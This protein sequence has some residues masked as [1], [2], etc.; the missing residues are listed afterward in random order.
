MGKV[1]LADRLGNVKRRH[2]GFSFLYLFL[3]P[4]YLLYRL[5]F[6]S[7]IIIIILGYYLIP[8]P[9]MNNIVGWLNTFGIPQNV[10]SYISRTLLFFRKSL[11]YQILG[12]VIFALVHLFL[13]RYIEGF[14]LKR[15]LKRKK[16]LPV[17]E[18]DARLLIR[19]FAAKV[20]V[21]LA[22]SFD[23]RSMKGYR[24]AEEDWYA[25][26]KT[27]LKN[28]TKATTKTLY[29]N[30]FISKTGSQ[31]NALKSSEAQVQLEQLQNIYNLGLINREQ[32]EMRRKKI[33]SSKK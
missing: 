7:A 8:I 18:N 20:N 21:P 27:R 25:Q 19:N 1:E 2:I 9:G 22:E 30:S 28:K 24:T 3:G 15:Q 23:I 13:A 14:L 5:R 12:C 10:F 16:Y 11:P 29:G 17:T 33:L 26:N 32:Y 4:L 6:F 31:T